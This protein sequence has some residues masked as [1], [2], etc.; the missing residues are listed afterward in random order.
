MIQPWQKTSDFKTNPF[1]L[2]LK[3]WDNHSL[4]KLL[5]END[6]K[7]FIFRGI[8]SNGELNIY[9]ISYYKN[10]SDWL[11]NY[12]LLNDI[13]WEDGS[14][15]Y[16]T[17]VKRNWHPVIWRNIKD[18]KELKEKI[19]EVMKKYWFEENNEFSLKE[20]H[21][22]CYLNNNDNSTD[23]IYKQWVVK[24]FNEKDATIKVLQSLPENHFNHINFAIESFNE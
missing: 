11:Y 24:A 1:I 7:S 17:S 8:D 16:A 5:N 13:E 14:Y 20:Y 6:Y 4:N 10:D 2:T 18:K 22:T 9:S 21:Y 3:G 19:I 23:D 15:W 12:N